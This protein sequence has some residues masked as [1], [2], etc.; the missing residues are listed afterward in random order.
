MISRRSFYLFL[1]FICFVIFICQDHLAFAF[2]DESEEL[3]E[4]YQTVERKKSDASND[5]SY[6]DII[7]DAGDAHQ[8]WKNE[9]EKIDL[10]FDNVDLKHSLQ[11]IS[12]G[13]DFNIVVDPS[14]AG[15]KVDLHLKSV[16]VK[17]ALQLLC[18]AH[19]LDSARVGDSLF[20]STKEKIKEMALVKK[21]IK[22]KNIRAPDAQ[23]LMA[24][25]AESISF[26]SDLNTLVVVGT[27]KQIEEME[28]V[29]KRI[30]VQQLQVEL[31]AQIIEI[32]S[33]ALSETG[34]DWSDNIDYNF[35]ETKRPVTTDNSERIDSGIAYPFKLFRLARDATQ[36]RVNIHM[37]VSE[38]KAKI[39][40]NPKI[41]TMNEKEAE[42]FIGDRI[43]YEVT[44]I[45]GGVT[46][47]EVRFVEAGIKLRITPSI[48][49]DDF[50]VVEVK[51]EVSYIYSWRGPDDEYPWVRTRQ[52]TAN[53]RVRNGESFVI[54]G[55]M[56]EEESNNIDKVP[57]FGDL[58]FVGKLFQY[59]KDTL[60]TK[61]I[62]IAV[63]PI[64]KR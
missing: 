22:L 57:F 64:I 24:S 40:S 35:Q 28:R 31:E 5:F 26:N 56:G 53:V 8:P 39:L 12:E 10:T 34:I 46:T 49:E 16:S 38:D 37:L 54:G 23:S 9:T 36:F 60:D 20:V 2:W 59:K 11:V 62:V 25:L 43:P 47:T 4:L 58:P 52:A 14:V 6:L 17:E 29:V 63:T 55:L 51:P 3:K 21:V 1:L 42:I 45:S 41:T 50:V 19:G 33:N 48:I 30:D 13:G 15:K 27:P 44:L 18:N 7:E 32:D 61:E